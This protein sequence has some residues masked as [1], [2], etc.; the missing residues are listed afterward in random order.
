MKISL[1]MITKDEEKL[2]PRCLESVK[3]HVDEIIVVDTGSTD[4]T[5]P[6]AL[7]YGA[8]VYH[9]PWKQ[10][11]AE[12]RNFGIDR[13]KGNWILYLDADETLE[14]GEGLRKMSEEADDEITGYLL[15]IHNYSDEERTK[16]ERSFSMRLFRNQ[17]GMR[18]QGALHEYLPVQGVQV[19]QTNIIVHHDGYIPSVWDA[20]GKSSRNLAILQEEVKESPN[21]PFILY[22]LG[23]EYARLGQLQ[24][25]ISVYSQALGYMREENGYEA[26]LYKLLGLC[27]LETSQWEEGLSVIKRG[28]GKFPDY[29]DLYYVRGLLFE[30]GGFLLKASAD[31]LRCL[32]MD[33]QGSSRAYVLEDGVTSFRAFSCLGMIYMKQ[34]KRREALTA[35]LRT[36]QD[37]PDHPEAFLKMKELFDQD[38][39]EL[40]AFLEENWFQA[41][42]NPESKLSMARMLHGMED[43]RM[44][45]S[46]LEGIKE[47]ER[48]D[49]I[50][51]LMGTSAYFLEEFN[52]A[53]D[54]LS[55]ISKLDDRYSP[56]VPYLA[57]SLWITGKP[58]KAKRMLS[59]T[60]SPGEHYRLVAKMFLRFG[61]Q[62]LAEGLNYFPDS[63][64]LKRE[65]D[66]IRQVK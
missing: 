17:P 14:K 62:K 24:S 64:S 50:F 25:A 48:D 28:I 8:K 41:N 46:L 34:G 45:L 43:Y 63:E 29:P 40:L 57:G 55:K 12:A 54:Y 58:E 26:R 16:I 44:V 59:Q 42:G 35:Y 51:F 47:K 21:D 65:H 49:Q 37:R 5:C 53:I 22:N 20:K 36:L 31:F 18:F 6:I 10:N 2:L 61:E 13:A 27:Y 23:C 4:Q 38:G 52:Q 66:R 39:Q 56:T 60:A 19:G 1:C 30:K 7:S 3:D 11:F 33:G 9:I 32:E 15:Q